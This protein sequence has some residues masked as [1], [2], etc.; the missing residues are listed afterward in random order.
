MAI[1]KNEDM[2]ILKDIEL[3]LYNV[4]KDC[5]VEENGIFAVRK[6]DIKDFN[7]LELYF[8]LYAIIEE[9]EKEKVKANKKSNEYNKINREYHNISNSLYQARR[10]KNNEK[11]RYWEN[12]LE[13]YKNRK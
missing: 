9:S 3:Y 1:L 7:A 5:Y 4:N 6:G 11:I 2:E 10:R 12:K 13:E 8:K